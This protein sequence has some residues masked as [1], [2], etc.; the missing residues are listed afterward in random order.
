M[1]MLQ[2]GVAEMSPIPDFPTHA[3]VGWKRASGGSEDTN[4]ARPRFDIGEKGKGHGWT[5][6][7]RCA[8]THP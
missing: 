1:V 4:S 8:C 2:S 7:Q 6:S 5:L 3:A